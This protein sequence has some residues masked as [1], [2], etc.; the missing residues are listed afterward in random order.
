MKGKTKETVICWWC[1][2]GFDDEPFYEYELVIDRLGEPM[3]RI[4]KQAFDRG[5]NIRAELNDN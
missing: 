5:E 1:E 2:N 3:H 4:C